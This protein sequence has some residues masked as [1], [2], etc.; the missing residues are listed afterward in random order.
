MK[1]LLTLIIAILTSSTTIVCETLPVRLKDIANIIEARDN[2]LLGFGL[3]VG[4]RNTGDSKSTVFTD[5][6]L[7]NLLSKMGIYAGGREF[8]SRNIA[9]VMVTATLPP[10]IKKGQR[11]PVVVS[12]LGDSSSL[13]GGTL[14]ITPLKGSDLNTYAIAQGSV[15]IGGI[16]Q[17]SA[18]SRFYKNQTTV[19]RIPDGAIVEQEVPV[20][21]QDQRHITIV[22]KESNFITL[23]R[24][25]IAIKLE[26]Y[27]NAQAVDANTIKVPLED[28]DSTDL[29]TAIAT[30]EDIP[31]FIEK[32]IKSA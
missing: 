10:F 14:L 32:K 5:I 31:I 7:E 25:V 13:V 28:L 6:A 30:L 1:L 18:Q 16:A 11:I 9:A 24:A 8:N 20:T 2:Q 3:V 26:G 17:A 29:V 15:I 19:G 27:E 22:F 12:S 21:F 23:S 4:L